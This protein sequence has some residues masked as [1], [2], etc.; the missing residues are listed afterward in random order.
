[1]QAPI[2]NFV[3]AWPIGLNDT[4]FTGRPPQLTTRE[5]ARMMLYGAKYLTKGC[6]NIPLDVDSQLR[7]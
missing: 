5:Q 6:Y 7:F 4:R 1:M 2:S 3:S